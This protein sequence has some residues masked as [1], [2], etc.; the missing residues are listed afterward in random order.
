MGQIAE[1][2]YRTERGSAGI[3]KATKH[4]GVPHHG[5]SPQRFSGDGREANSGDYFGGMDCAHHVDT[6]SG[7]YTTPAG[8]PRRGSRSA[9][10]SVTGCVSGLLIHSHQAKTKRGMSQCW[11]EPI[12]I[13]S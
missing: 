7:A 11:L 12:S 8:L 3:Q 9:L 10:E 13:S 5:I 4:N 6:A 1:A 2:I